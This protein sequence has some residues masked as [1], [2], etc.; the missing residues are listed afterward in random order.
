[1]KTA[2]FVSPT[3]IYNLVKIVENYENC[4]I[5]SLPKKFDG[6]LQTSNSCCTEG[7]GVSEF[8]LEFEVTLTEK[9]TNV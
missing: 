1:M 2:T 7:A 4:I 3:V 6:G 8:L 9:L 5:V